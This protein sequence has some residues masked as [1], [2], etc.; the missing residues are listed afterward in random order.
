M[1]RLGLLL[2]ALLFLILG[3]FAALVINDIRGD[4]PANPTPTSTSTPAVAPNRGVG[5]V[6]TTG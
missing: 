4:E 6:T 3:G 2:L 5:Q 1:P